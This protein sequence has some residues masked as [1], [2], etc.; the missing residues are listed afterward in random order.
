[1]T[2]DTSNDFQEYTLLV[3]REELI[4]EVKKRFEILEVKTVQ[5]LQ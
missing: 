2:I 4:A 5:I 3:I 1:M